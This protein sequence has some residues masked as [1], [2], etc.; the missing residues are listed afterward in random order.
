MKYLR[1]F[2][3]IRPS[4]LETLEASLNAFYKVPPTGYH[5][6]ALA[7]NENWGAPDHEF[8]R[9]IA[10]SSFP[11][12]RVLDVGCG[13]ASAAAVFAAA[14]AAYTGIDVSAETIAADQARYPAL[15]FILGSW[16]D[17]PSAGAAFDLVFSL[18][19]L[20]HMVYPRDFLAAC[21]GAVRPGGL[22]A[23]LCP[24]YLRRGVLPSQHYFGL[25]PGGIKAK[26]MRGE[27]A[28]AALS[29]AEKF[30]SY[31]RL[32]RS[33]RGAAGGTWLM[34]LRPVCLESSG[35]RTDWDAVY[36]A[37][38]G[39][40]AGY[41]KELGFEIVERGEQFGNGAHGFCYVLARKVR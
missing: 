37:G 16:R 10:A 19:V 1:P 3:E 15:K 8:H 20:E 41:I 7:A 6:A 2:N 5:A 24:D 38:E 40:A 13:P 29:A 18:F 4:E 14:G 31:P 22:L 33:A 30:F 36:A 27:L 9:R 32:M 21:A 12:A 34:N 23:V 28:D 25:R 17:L 39:E 35:W 26:L 11:G